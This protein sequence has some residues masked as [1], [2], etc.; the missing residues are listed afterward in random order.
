MT[1]QIIAHDV[2]VDPVVYKQMAYAKVVR[3]M[4]LIVPPSEKR[5]DHPWFHRFERHFRS[6][7]VSQ[8]YRKFV[9]ALMYNAFKFFWHKIDQQINQY[10]EIH[11]SVDDIHGITVIRIIRVFAYEFEIL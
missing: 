3:G 8:P 11:V 9:Y 4:R 5:I 1:V 7:G 10:S 2:L 6:R